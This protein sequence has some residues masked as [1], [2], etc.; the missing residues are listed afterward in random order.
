MP[1]FIPSDKAIEGQLRYTLGGQYAQNSLWFKCGGPPTEQNLLDVLQLLKIGWATWR[2]QLTAA[3]TLTEVRAYDRTA[4]VAPSAVS[5]DIVDPAGVVAGDYLPGNCAMCVSLR[6]GFGNRS[7]RGRMYIPGIP[8]ART[9][10]A[11]MATELRDAGA[12]GIQQILINQSI[13]G[14]TLSVCSKYHEGQPRPLGVMT[15]I[16]SAYV[17][18]YVDSQ[19]RRLPK[20]GR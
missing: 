14:L 1:D 3:L 18:E 9:T 20:R 11:S 12:A 13:M 19:R 7:A 5:V 6:T 16:T 10:G 2:V 17:D 8:E 4:Q 15:P